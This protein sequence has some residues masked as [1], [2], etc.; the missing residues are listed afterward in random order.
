MLK[1]K[2][3]LDVAETFE[4]RYV[5]VLRGIESLQYSLE[6]TECNFALSAYKYADV[7]NKERPAFRLFRLKG[8]LPIST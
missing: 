4:E 1:A 7:H 8:E 2:S 6:L 3:G 5:D